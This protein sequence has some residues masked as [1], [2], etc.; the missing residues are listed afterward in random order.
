MKTISAIIKSAMQDDRSFDT[1]ERQ[2][3]AVFHGNDHRAC[4]AEEAAEMVRAW[5]SKQIDIAISRGAGEF[6]AED[7]A[8][9]MPRPKF[10][11]ETIVTIVNYKGEEIGQMLASEA[12]ST[13]IRAFSGKF[14]Q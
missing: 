8:Y 6:E 5:L 3:A 13:G 14:R 9:S 10:E 1:A 2:Y 12:E 11:G 4:C 7:E